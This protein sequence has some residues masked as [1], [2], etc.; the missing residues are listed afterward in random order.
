MSCAQYNRGPFLESMWVQDGWMV[1][2]ARGAISRLPR[3]V[4]VPFRMAETCQF[5]KDD[6]YQLPDCIG[7]SH[8]ESHES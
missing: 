1:H 8:K 5:Q 3:M 4:H 7:C 2:Q 6:K